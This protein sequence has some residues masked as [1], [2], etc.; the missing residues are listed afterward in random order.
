MENQRLPKITLLFSTHPSRWDF[1]VCV[2]LFNLQV[3]TLLKS[4][5]TFAGSHKAVLGLGFRFR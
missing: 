3:K 2:C 1:D 5:D 4:E